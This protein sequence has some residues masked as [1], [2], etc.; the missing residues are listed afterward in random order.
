MSELRAKSEWMRVNKP[1]NR[2]RGN[3][4][5]LG[6]AVNDSTYVVD[7]GKATG[8]TP[9]PA[10]KCW[11]R[12]LI[13]CYSAPFLLK[14][15]TYYGVSVCEPWL[16]FSNFREWWLSNVVDGWELDKDLLH[17]DNTIYSPDKCVFVPKWLNRF[18]N[19]CAAGRGEWPIGVYY[20]KRDRKFR[21]QL[22]VDKG[23]QITLG[24]FSTAEEAH[25]AWLNAKLGVAL[26]KKSDMDAIDLRIYPNVTAKILS[27]K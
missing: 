12:M 25:A 15:P 11:V 2:K 5:M 14:N 18:L 22:S 16:I 13:R 17:I 4:R 1:S 23:P 20:H 26:S 19:D 9:C 7:P 27:M 3:R 10:Y 6:G 21:G 8:F 24:S